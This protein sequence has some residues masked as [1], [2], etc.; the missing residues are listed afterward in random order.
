MAQAISVQGHLAGAGGHVCSSSCILVVCST[1]GYGQEPIQD[2]V[3]KTILRGP[4][5]PSVRWEK[6]RS[7]SAVANTANVRKDSKKETK[8]KDSA[9][10]QKV[11]QGTIQSSVSS[12][13]TRGSSSQG[14]TVARSAQ[15]VGRCRCGREGESGT[16]PLT[17]TDASCGATHDGTDHLHERIYRPGEETVGCRR[18]GSSRSCP[19]SRRVHQSL[20]RGREA[21]GRIAGEEFCRTCP[22]GRVDPASSASG[23]APG[24]G[25]SFSEALKAEGLSS[26]GHARVDSSRV[27]SLGHSRDI[28]L[29]SMVTKGAER[30]VEMTRLDISDDEFRSWAA[31][32]RV[33]SPL[34]DKGA[35][36]K[37][38]SQVRS[39]G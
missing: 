10:F 8:S 23:R 19:E 20:G 29:S 36:I 11:V 14:P 31:Q 2:A 33:G 17:R 28:E 37:M 38:F 13:D 39:E 32:E 18:G 6:Q 27:V 7:E 12:G 1:S 3:W 4:R 34:I 21:P 16:G 35:H 25:E 22:R 5:P 24:I 15:C 26:G 9:K 30:M